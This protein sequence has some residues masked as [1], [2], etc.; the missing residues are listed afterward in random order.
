[1]LFQNTCV[2]AANHWRG[3]SNDSGIIENVNFS[4]FWRYIFGTLGNKANIMKTK[5]LF[6]NLALHLKHT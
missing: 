3:A 5:E 4:A 2:F 1:M 6:D